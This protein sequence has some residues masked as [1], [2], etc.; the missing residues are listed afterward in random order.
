[1]QDQPIIR[2]RD[3]NR[4]YH[5]EG[6][7]VHAVR[8][9]NMDIPRGIMSAIVGRSGA[10]KTTLLNLLS[11]LDEPSSGEVWIDDTNVFALPEPK[12]IALRRDRVGFVFQ[13]F[14]LLPLLSAAENISVPLRMKRMNRKQREERVAE[15]LEWVGLSKRASHRPYE[16]SGGEQQRVSIARAL[17]ARPDIILADEPTGQLDSQT[18]KTVLG[19]MQRLVDEQGITMVIVTHDPQVMGQAQATFELSDGQL[20]NS[21]HQPMGTSS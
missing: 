12:R 8:D 14:G 10:G 19:I 16:L 18:G 6:E 4:V 1:M 21:E 9:V 13:N 15:A 20:V 17:A 5:L 11:A 7:D 2:V 3:L